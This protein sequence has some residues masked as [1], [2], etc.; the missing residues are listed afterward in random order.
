M[1]KFFFSITIIL[2]SLH[3]ACGQGLHV[4]STRFITGD[5][6]CTGVNYTIA[7]IDKGILFVGVSTRNPGG[8]IPY[9]PLDTSGEGNLLLCKIDSNQKISWLKLYGG[10][11]GDGG[12]TACQ[13]YDGGFAVLG[14]TES[15]D[16]DVTEKRG[17]MWVL[18]LNAAGDI[19]WDRTYG[20]SGSDIPISIVSAPD[21]GFILYGATNGSDGDVPFHY[22][23]TWTFDWIVI[24]TDRSGQLKWAKN[25]GG[26]GDEKFSGSV[27]SVDTN[28]YIIGGT[29]SKNG[30]CTDT[31]WHWKV[32]TH[33]DCFLFKLDAAGNILWNRSYGGTGEDNIMNAI[34]DERDSTIVIVGQTNSN[35]YM[36]KGALGSKD[37][38]VVKADKDGN[39]IWQKPLGGAEEDGGTSIVMTQSGGYK[40]YGHTN[41]NKGLQKFW[42]F[43]ID[44]KG[45]IISDKVFG[46]GPNDV[47][48]SHSITHYLNGYAVSGMSRAEAFTEGSTYG[49]FAYS[50]PFISYL[51]YGT[52]HE[53]ELGNMEGTE[54]EVYPNPGYEKITISNSKKRDGIISVINSSGQEVY[55]YHA[56]K[57]INNIEVNIISWAGGVYIVRW[58]SS[59]GKISMA[60]FAKL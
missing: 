52:L 31:A 18:R 39:L 19:L 45:N 42:L 17:G 3:L 5:K 44:S 10:S 35:D 20:S 50:G 60:K 14:A 41:N 11:R 4:D 46:G 55:T 58:Q 7:T 40:I 22:G 53:A 32:D 57:R 48:T 47:A 29:N 6:C 25:I 59:D 51:S 27:L 15:N 24:K 36:V 9:F 38:W 49:K 21:S 2:G 56:T 33:T 43:E 1:K 12:Y 8:I 54:M 23:S 37:M 13:T 26:H 30:D 34:Y 28:Y 16:G